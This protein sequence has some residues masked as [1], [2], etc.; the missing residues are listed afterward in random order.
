LGTSRQGSFSRH[1]LLCLF[2]AVVV[3]VHSWSVVQLLREVPAW[4]LFLSGWRLF[5]IVAY[6]QAWAL[7]E[8]L[9]VLL[10]FLVLARLL[11][12]H[13]FRD[14]MLAQGSALVLVSSAWASAA[15]YGDS[16]LRSWGARGFGLVGVLYLVS[17]V[18]T[19]WWMSKSPRLQKLSGS[20]AERLSVFLYLYVPLSVLSL[21]VV[22]VRNLFPAQ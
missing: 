14:R 1:E 17:I 6:T 15:H 2:A 3:P 12:A 9:A 11:P 13:W 20:L 5:S 10:G 16:L 8:S 7:L 18:G 21:S 4:I 22:V 19:G